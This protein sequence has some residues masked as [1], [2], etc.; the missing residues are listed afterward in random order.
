M[1]MR[2]LP[3]QF[4]AAVAASYADVRVDVEDR[5][6]G[7][8]GVAIDQCGGQVQLDERFPDS[9]VEGQR[10]RVDRQRLE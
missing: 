9:L 4:R 10:V 1:A 7:E 5:V 2:A 8:I 3:E 6:M